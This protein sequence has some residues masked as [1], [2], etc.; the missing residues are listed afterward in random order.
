MAMTNYL[1]LLHPLLTSMPSLLEVTHDELLQIQHLCHM[2]DCKR[3]K[4]SERQQESQKKEK[5]RWDYLHHQ[6]YLDLFVL[7]VDDEPPPQLPICPPP[8][9]SRGKAIRHQQQLLFPNQQQQQL[10]PNQLPNRHC[11]HHCPLTSSAI[12]NVVGIPLLPRRTRT[13]RKIKCQLQKSKEEGFGSQEDTPNI[14][15]EEGGRFT[16]GPQEAENHSLVVRLAKRLLRELAYLWGGWRLLS[17]TS[18]MAR[19][20]G[21]GF[22]QIL[23]C[24][25]C[26]GQCGL[27][28]VDCCHERRAEAGVCP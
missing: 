16:E 3:Q 15:K 22:Y 1:H 17:L 11:P 14:Q 27:P 5:N 4:E 13:I 2:A 28:P 25:L 23:R 24:R 10:F 20:E 9:A 26:G 12:C 8:A 21:L 7:D 18:P 19:C 6:S